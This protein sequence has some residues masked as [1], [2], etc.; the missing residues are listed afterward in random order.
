[1]SAIKRKSFRL[2]VF[3][4]LVIAFLAIAASF[5]SP[6]IKSPWETYVD[7]R[8]KYVK[9]DSLIENSKIEVV[10]YYNGDEKIPL[11][12]VADVM[13][14]GTG[15]SKPFTQKQHAWFKDQGIVMNESDFSGWYIVPRDADIIQK[16]K[17]L[18]FIKRGGELYLQD[19]GL[20]TIIPN[21]F[22]VQFYEN[23]S[24]EEVIRINQRYGVSIVKKYDYLGNN[25]LLEVPW[26]SELTALDL[27]NLYHELSLTEYAHPNFKRPM[28]LF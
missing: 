6:N 20:Q 21:N 17:T 8:L 7:W 23:V 10:Y 14:V 28:I 12:H 15:S 13:V 19:D 16:L 24:E 18:D 25:Y 9:D 5:I 1:M 4:L 22:F 26:D 27:A 3:S 2:I 11:N